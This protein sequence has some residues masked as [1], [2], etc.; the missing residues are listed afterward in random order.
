MARIKLFGFRCDRCAHEW[1]PYEND[2]EPAECPKCKS[3]HWEESSQTRQPY[4]VFKATV[5]KT[6]REAGGPL[7]W[8]E[9]KTISGLHQKFPNNKWVRRMEEDI[10]LVRQKTAGGTTLWRLKDK[11]EA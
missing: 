9:V 4:D 1:V 5:E 11:A 6:L 3:P 7:T 10:G 8:T 2:S